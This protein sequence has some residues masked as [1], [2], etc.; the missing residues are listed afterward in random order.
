MKKNDAPATTPI[1]AVKWANAQIMYATLA[2]MKMT[3][4]VR[5]P[6]LARGE[7][8]EAFG[9]PGICTRRR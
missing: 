4:K 9:P 7:K 6:R 2:A 3:S 5:Q 8:S 1:A